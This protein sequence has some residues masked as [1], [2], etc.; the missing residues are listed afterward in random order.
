MNA[1]QHVQ[2]MHVLFFVLALD[3]TKLIWNVAVK[4]KTP[5]SSSTAFHAARCSWGFVVTTAIGTHGA[6]KDAVENTVPEKE[7]HEGFSFSREMR[8]LLQK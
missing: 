6:Q 4:L 7:T 3:T 8:E 2:H 1:L 5:V